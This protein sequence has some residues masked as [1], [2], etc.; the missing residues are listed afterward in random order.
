MSG[1]ERGGLIGRQMEILLVEDGLLAARLAMA[2]VQKSNFPNRL[3]WLS[4]G[5][6]ATLFLR[7]EGKYAHAVR[8]DLILLDLTLPKRDGR[9]ILLEVRNSPDLKSIPVVIMTSS[10]DERDLESGVQMHVDGYL[11]KPV[12]ITRFQELLRSL[13]S[14]WQDEEIHFG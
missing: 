7:R 14:H 12:D 10:T 8:P 2:A 13:R 1:K 3:T 6:D 5:H 11:T 4:D 9:E